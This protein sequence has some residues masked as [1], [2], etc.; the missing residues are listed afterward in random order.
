MGRFPPLL[1][2]T[3]LVGGYR[4]DI[5]LILNCFFL[6][7]VQPQK[8]HKIDLTQDYPCPC[9]RRG[10]LTPIALTDA[11]GCD[12]CQQI[13]VVDEGGHV[14]EQLSTT[15]PYKRAWRWNGQQ[16]ILVTSGLGESYLPVALGVI[17]VLL[18]IWLPLALNAPPNSGILL[19]AM[20]ALLLAVLP[21]LMVL[22]TYRR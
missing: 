10:R 17:L 8:A 19:W 16:W 20:V 12:R 1:I 9:R 15:Y 4:V 14:L 13:F 5:S 2:K 22:L 18:S 6:P 21:A 7:T 3:S 11:F